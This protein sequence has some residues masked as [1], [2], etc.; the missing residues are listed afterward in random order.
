MAPGRADTFHRAGSDQARALC[1]LPQALPIAGR[2]LWRGVAWN[3]GKK[4]ASVAASREVEDARDSMGRI[5]EGD[6]NG[7]RLFYSAS[8]AADV[9][10]GRFWDEVIEDGLRFRFV[11]VKL[12]NPGWFRLRQ[13]DINLSSVFVGDFDGSFYKHRDAVAYSRSLRVFTLKSEQVQTIAFARPAHY[14]VSQLVLSPEWAQ[15]MLGKF[16]L[17]P[18]H[19]LARLH[20]AC[21][22]GRQFAVR[23]HA[24]A[25][26]LGADLL[27]LQESSILSP[28]RRLRLKARAFDMLDRTLEAIEAAAAIEQGTDPRLALMHRCAAILDARYA[29]PPS[30]SELADELGMGVDM[31]QR[32][33]KAA[34]GVSIRSW[35]S[36]RRMHRAAE[37]LMA[38][39]SAVA[40][41]GY[42]VG[43]SNPSA[44]TR[45][46]T[47]AFGASP[48]EYRQS[49][50]SQSCA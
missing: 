24:L 41:V 2:M 22:H 26:D 39:S 4:R 23:N 40:N 7:A 13:A 42:E 33:F 3:R 11:D 18:E 20:S 48:Q 50:Q 21:H 35:L 32:S 27:G 44:F 9:T 12:T 19:N 14:R 46:F 37:L 5:I 30:L 31:L 38:R 16:D 8:I 49:K 10:Q 47:R 17:A 25:S 29:D 6:P 15:N 43:Y 1:R 36:D 34:H 28:R 45:A